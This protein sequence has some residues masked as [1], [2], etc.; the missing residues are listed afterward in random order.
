M[1]HERL[2]A[3]ALAI[4]PSIAVA[5]VLLRY[6][7][8]DIY[9]GPIQ[10]NPNVQSSVSVGLDAFAHATTTEDVDGT[11]PDPV[12]TTLPTLPP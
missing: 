7:V 12:L 10:I 2:D 6:W 4:K 8:L 1:N 9:L 3:E 11:T 5:E